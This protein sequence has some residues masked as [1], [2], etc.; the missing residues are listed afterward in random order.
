[1]VGRRCA[2]QKW[3]YLIVSSAYDKG[4]DKAKRVNGQELQNWKRTD[5][6]E[7]INQLGEEGWELV[8]YSADRF[9]NQYMA[10]KRPK[11]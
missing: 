7:Y 11:Q 5:L 8:G 3:E 1:M 6:Y 9:A 4:N 10:L 2:V